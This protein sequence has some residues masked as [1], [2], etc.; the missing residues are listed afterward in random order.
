MNKNQKNLMVMSVFIVLAIMT[1]LFLPVKAKLIILI[2]LAT[3]WI[4]YCYW[5][6]IIGNKNEE[7]KEAQV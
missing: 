1:L 7:N 2:V 6:G 5:A 3:L 4:R